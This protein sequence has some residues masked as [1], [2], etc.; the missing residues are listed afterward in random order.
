MAIIIHLLQA[1]F[2]SR[3]KEEKIVASQAPVLTDQRVA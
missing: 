1:I 2:T 3:Y